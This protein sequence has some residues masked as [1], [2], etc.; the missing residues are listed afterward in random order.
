MQRF[1]D[2]L[3]FVGGTRAVTLQFG[4]FDVGVVDVVVDPR[5]IHLAAFAVDF[6]FYLHN[7]EFGS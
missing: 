1:I 6:H 2:F 7:P 5:P 4:E 3:E